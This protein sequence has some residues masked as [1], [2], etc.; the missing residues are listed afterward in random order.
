MSKQNPERDIANLL[1]HNAGKEIYGRCGDCGLARRFAIAPL[2][3]KYGKLMHLAQLSYRLR[4][5]QCGR[6]GIPLQF[7]AWDAPDPDKDFRPI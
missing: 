5:Q 7:V 6:R 4:C 2:A 3:R 1:G